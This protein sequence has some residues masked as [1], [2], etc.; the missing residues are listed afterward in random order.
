MVDDD[1]HGMIS[2]NEHDN[3][4]SYCVDERNQCIDCLHISANCKYQD[5]I[6]LLVQKH[7]EMRTT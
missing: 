2:S 4:V 6:P 3:C 7:N 5:M 1:L